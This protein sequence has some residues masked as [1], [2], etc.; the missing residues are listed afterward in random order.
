MSR[1]PQQFID[2]LLTRV[3][4]VEVI[5]RRVPLTKKGRE[6]LACCPF[7][8]EKTPSFKVNE[9]RQF[10]HCFGCGAG[11]NAIGFLMQYANLGFLEAVESLAEEAGMPVPARETGGRKQA[12]STAPLRAIVGEANKWFQRQLRVHPG[13]K[14][15]VEY[16]K[17]RGLS[18]KI[19]A[20]F[21]LG[22]APDGWDNL[23]RALGS[24]AERRAQLEK[25]GLAIPGGRDGLYDRFRARIMFPIE[26]Y[27]GR[28]VG[29]G[30]RSI[31]DADG[32]KYLNSPQTPLFQK[33]VELYGL[34]RARRAIGNAKSGILVEGY[35]D[36][37]GLAQFGV[38]NAVATLGTAIARGHIQR[39][40]RAGEEIVFCFDGDRAGRATAWK[41]LQ[42]A[43]PEVRDGRHLRFLFLPNGE[44]P[45][46]IIRGEGAD[47]FRRRAADAVG[48]DAFLFD[49]LTASVD[50]KSQGG[51]AEL[52]AQ[53]KPLLELMPR[54]ALREMMSNRLLE[55]SGLSGW[56]LQQHS[57]P[58]RLPRQG[59]EVQTQLSPLALAISLLLQDPSLAATAELD[60]L[61]SLRLPGGDLLLGLLQYVARDPNITTAR[62]LEAYRNDENYAHL[63][64]LAM[65]ENLVQTSGDAAVAQF[66]DLLA[67]LL[68]M[69]AE[70][71]R[72]ALIEKMRLAN[73]R[74][75][76][77]ALQVEM[78]ALLERR[79]ARL[80][81]GEEI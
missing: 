5:D 68:E 70:R 46:S 80:Q 2:Q 18:G 65:R 41:A 55:L 75:E 74:E 33:G 9:I 79:S 60:E 30:G 73:T 77:R 44:D 11:G 61:Q 20:E 21:G 13:A 51:R 59:G 3:N 19:A 49:T 23:L 66:A 26:D 50:M 14:T 16:L 69:D 15:A 10:Y 6:H 43:L 34:H 53:A 17:G 27:R 62:L 63:E 72:L 25:A 36:V 29:F 12:D 81:S 39:L 45:D 4:I 76:Q 31:G 56:Q 71:R 24:N 78:K 1:I 40:F 52:V 8:E 42:V 47:G 7:H 64:K 35:M 22:F 38:D 32:A 37:V 48:L 58:M 67:R 54:C 28:V 57:R